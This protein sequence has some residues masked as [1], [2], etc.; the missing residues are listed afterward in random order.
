DHAGARSILA[1]I[2]DDPEQWAIVEAFPDLRTGVAYA[3]GMGRMLRGDV[4]GAAEI[5][6]RVEGD[7][8]EADHLRRGLAQVELARGELEAAARLLDDSPEA[9]RFDRVLTAQ[10]LWRRGD[11]RAARD[12]ARRELTMPIRPEDHPWDVAG[13]LQQAGRI[14][15]DAG[16]IGPAVEASAQMRRLLYGAPDTLPLLT[17]LALLEA[18]LER[19]G[20]RPEAALNRLAGLT[21]LD[22]TDLAEWHRERARALAALGRA[23]EAASTYAAAIESFSTAG[24]RWEAQATH[25]EAGA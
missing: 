7:V 24:E 15:A 18:A 22:G 6:R 13:A 23:D 16:E 3:V 21:G 1:P 19:V 4:D 5:L 12:R 9:A 17:H 25:D 10:L 8:G 2:I 20:G 14:L 11:R